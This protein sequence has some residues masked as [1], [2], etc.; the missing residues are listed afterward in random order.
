MFVADP[1]DFG[2]EDLGCHVG[3]GGDDG[4]GLGSELAGEV[5]VFGFGQCDADGPEVR[6]V[7]APGGWVRAIFVTR[8][9]NQGRHSSPGCRT[10][11]LGS[12]PPK[13]ET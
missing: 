9:V 13:S 6:D 5:Q 1:G 12:I 7:V 11:V 10:L 2:L 8:S 3:E 4:R